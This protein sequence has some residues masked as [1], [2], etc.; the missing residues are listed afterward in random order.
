M[1]TPDGYAEQGWNRYG[2]HKYDQ[3]LESFN[4]AVKLNPRNAYAYNGRGCVWAAKRQYDLATADFNRAFQLEP[5]NPENYWCRAQLW[6]AKK[7]YDKA[8]ADFNRAVQL[9]PKYDNAYDSLAWLQATCPDRRYRDGKAACANAKKAYELTEERNW[10]YLDTIAAAYAETGDFEQARKWQ[11]KAV[12]I[13]EMDRYDDTRK[14]VS[15]S[16]LELYRQNKPYREKSDLST[17]K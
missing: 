6:I 10:Y 15:R 16:R 4:W 14:K 13:A 3:A 8:L 17:G 11:A 5:K 1:L 9:D 7:E 12:E 2:V